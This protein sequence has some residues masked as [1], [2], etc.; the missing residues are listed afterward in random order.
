MCVRSRVCVCVSVSFCLFGESN[1]TL[2]DSTVRG[3]EK[4]HRIAFQLILFILFHLLVAHSC[5]N[6]FINAGISALCLIVEMS[7]D[8]RS[9]CDQCGCCCVVV[10][11]VLLCLS[12]CRLRSFASASS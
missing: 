11:M 10:V 3:S 8:T 6:L 2:S 9:F 7:I 12:G 4:A 1:Q 5:L